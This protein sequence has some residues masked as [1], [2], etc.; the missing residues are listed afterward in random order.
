M[1]LNGRLGNSEIGG[2]KEIRYPFANPSPT[3][4]QPCEL[5]GYRYRLGIINSVMIYLS[6]QGRF[7]LQGLEYH[8]SSRSPGPA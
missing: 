7:F 2:C 6:I 3:L 1:S 5:R 8:A 4:R